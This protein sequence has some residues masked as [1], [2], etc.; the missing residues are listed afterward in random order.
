MTG[1]L[2]VVFL[3]RDESVVEAAEV[4]ALVS[5]HLHHQHDEDGD[6]GCDEGVM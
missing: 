5:A 1:E 3:L 4:E 6:V 2:E